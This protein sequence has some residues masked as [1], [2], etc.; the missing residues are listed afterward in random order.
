[1]FTGHSRGS[2]TINLLAAKLIDNKTQMSDR[3]LRSTLSGK[4]TVIQTTR[5][6][7]LDPIWN[8]IMSNKDYSAEEK[9]VYLSMKNRLLS[10]MFLHQNFYLLRLVEGN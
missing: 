5:K 3:Q 9:N 2:A 1:M 8:S 10:W 4:Q 6:A 7:I